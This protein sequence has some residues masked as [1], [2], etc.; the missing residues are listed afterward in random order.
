MNYL[1]AKRLWVMALV[2]AFSVVVIPA[3]DIHVA[4]TGTDMGDGTEASR[5][6]MPTV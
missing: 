6:S 4:T 5:H 1:P 2:L 3:K